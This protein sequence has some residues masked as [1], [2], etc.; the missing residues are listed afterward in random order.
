MGEYEWGSPEVIN[1][2]SFHWKD[3][4]RF[5]LRIGH[6]VVIG[7]KSDENGR[8]VFVSRCVQ[9]SSN[10]S[11]PSSACVFHFVPKVRQILLT[12]N[13]YVELGSLLGYS[14]RYISIIAVL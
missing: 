8:R 13:I 7:V 9:V 2:Y 6:S 3:T 11:I 12:T 5:Y 1:F 14:K 4:I 10:T